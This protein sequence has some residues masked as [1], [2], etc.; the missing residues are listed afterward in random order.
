MSDSNGQAGGDTDA[1]DQSGDD[2][3]GSIAV[4][5]VSA[6]VLKLKAVTPGQETRA[7][8]M[9]IV[10]S[11]DLI[12][13]KLPTA[14]MTST[15]IPRHKENIPEGSH[16]PVSVKPTSSSSPLKEVTQPNSPACSLARDSHQSNNHRGQRRRYNRGG[17]RGRGRHGH[18]KTPDTPGAAGSHSHTH[19]AHH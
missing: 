8:P 16:G 2:A 6:P 18:A 4:R 7:S 15:P 12:S 17:G 11:K 19:G 9:T 10:I 3:D 5:H 13:N 1:T 14:A